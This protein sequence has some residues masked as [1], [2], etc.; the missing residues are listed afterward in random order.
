MP[1]AAAVRQRNL[2]LFP[3]LAPM[4]AIDK[5]LI[6]LSTFDFRLSWASDPRDSACTKLNGNVCWDSKHMQSPMLD[7]KAEGCNLHADSRP[8]AAP[9]PTKPRAATSSPPLLFLNLTLSVECGGRISGNG[10]VGPPTTSGN[11]TNNLWCRLK[12]KMGHGAL[13]MRYFQVMP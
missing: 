7:S 6:Q 2:V 13:G 9:L 5:D 4:P 11:Y 8:C 1:E 12:Y 10:V 3:L